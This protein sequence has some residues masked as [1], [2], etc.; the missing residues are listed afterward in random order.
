MAPTITFKPSMISSTEMPEKL[1]MFAA[2]AMM[3]AGWAR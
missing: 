1:K 3:F 2:A